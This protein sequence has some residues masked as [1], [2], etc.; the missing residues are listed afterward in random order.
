MQTFMPC[1]P[2]DSV[3]RGLEL[4]IINS[5]YRTGLPYINAV[6]IYWVN[7]EPGISH[8]TSHFHFLN[9]VNGDTLQREPRAVRKGARGDTAG[10]RLSWSTQDHP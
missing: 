2:T 9:F 7:Y 5:A 3:C 6:G 1:S 4:V 10:D 8:I